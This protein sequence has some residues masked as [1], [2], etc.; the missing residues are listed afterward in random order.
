MA[1]KSPSLNIHASCVLETTFEHVACVVYYLN[2]TITSDA[3]YMRLSL[4]TF[5]VILSHKLKELSSRKELSKR[6]IAGNSVLSGKKTPIH[7]YCRDDNK[8][9]IEYR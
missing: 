3:D 7:W 6:D 9:V 1:S 5:Y 4:L 2:P 8:R